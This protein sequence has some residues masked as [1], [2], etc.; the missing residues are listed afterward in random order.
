MNPA[1]TDSEQVMCKDKIG[2]LITNVLASLAL[3]AA[4]KVLFRSRFVHVATLGALHQF[5]TLV[6][7]LCTRRFKSISGRPRSAP[8]FLEGS[9]YALLFSTSV[10]SMNLSL[11]YNQ[12]STYQVIKVG[13]LPAVAILESKVFQHGLPPDGVFHL[14]LVVVGSLVTIV[15]DLNGLRIS[16]VG[17][18]V[19]FVAVLSTALQTVFLKILQNKYAHTDGLLERLSLLCAIFMAA[20]GPFIDVVIFKSANYTSDIRQLALAPDSTL[21]RGVALTCILAGILNVSQFHIVRCFNALTFQVV[22]HVK[23][24]CVVILGPLVFGETLTV[25]KVA[26]VMLVFYGSAR[27][28]KRR[29]CPKFRPDSGL[30]THSRQL[31][32]SYSDFLCFGLALSVPMLAYLLNARHVPESPHFIS[33]RNLDSRKSSYL[34]GKVFVYPVPE[35]ILNNGLDR[36]SLVSWEYCGGDPG[37]ALETKLAPLIL[38]SEYTTA[39]PYEAK[40]YFVPLYLTCQLHLCTIRQNAGIESMQDCAITRVHEY[41]HNIMHFVTSSYPFFNMTGGV[42]HLLVVTHEFL[43]EYLSGLE[44]IQHMVFVTPHGLSPGHKLLFKTTN[45]KK[46]I[47]C[48]PMSNHT[49]LHLTKSRFYS[50]WQKKK[51]LAYFRGALHLENHRYSSGS[52]QHAARLFSNRTDFFFRSESTQETK[53]RI[54]MDSAKFCMFFS[55]WVPWSGR[56]AHIIQAGCIPVI[57]ADAIV[58]PHEDLIDWRSF[59]IKVS[60]ARLEMLPEILSGISTDSAWELV[61]NLLVARQALLYAS[62]PEKGD[63]LH[64]IFSSLSTRLPVRKPAAY[65]EW[66]IH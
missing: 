15:D 20:A 52:R 21:Q 56:L 12:V 4:N 3:V 36:D 40:A 8:R 63:A 44:D 16:L 35:N 58:L 57:I 46:D 22:G 27:Y 33:S 11:R 25:P 53:Y 66:P 34:E 47:V 55:G 14:F 60:Y 5:C 31:T 59:S 19:A 62:P 18:L 39:D 61:Q 6:I 9:G 50:E 65:D 17:V 30:C 42:D 38:N 13:T 2:L 37:Y 54:E 41:L 10:I 24:A 49:A 45:T 32:S 28:S 7:S 29:S 1:L 51:Y 64:M 26:G 23:T 43:Y 48:M